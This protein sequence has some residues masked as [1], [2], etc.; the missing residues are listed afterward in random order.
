MQHYYLTDEQR[1]LME[2]ARALAREAT[3]PVL[4][5]PV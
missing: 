5:R 3:R 4:A 1:M 2:L